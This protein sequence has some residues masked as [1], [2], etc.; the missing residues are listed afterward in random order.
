MSRWRSRSQANPQRRRPGC[1]ATCRSIASTSPA[2]SGRCSACSPSRDASFVPPSLDLPPLDLNVRVGA[3]D[4]GAGQTARGF[5][6]R[7]RTDRGRFDLDDV[8]ADLSGSHASGRLTVRR[9]AALAAVTGQVSLDSLAR[10]SAGASRPNRRRIQLRRFGR[11]RR[12]A[13]WRIGG[14]G[15]D[16]TARRFSAASRSR[17]AQARAGARAGRRIGIDETNVGYALGLELDRAAL[18]LPDGAAP[19][20]LSAGVIR[21]GP[22]AVARAGGSTTANA[23]FDLRAQSLR[24]TS[25][26]PRRAAANSGTGRR[27][28]SMCR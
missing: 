10:R 20:T 27:R 4:L 18:P 17:R 14:G 19:A 28:Q 16:R 24:S 23:A 15:E 22:L 11:Q 8:A 21:V 7:L 12:R 5:E 9:D 6:A 2:C 13:G 25:P 26:S 1:K 3:F